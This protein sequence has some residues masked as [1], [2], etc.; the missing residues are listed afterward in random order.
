MVQ[1]GGVIKAECSR[2]V[3]KALHIVL[4]LTSG[5]SDYVSDASVIGD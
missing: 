4:N 5:C 1:S 2:N 3:V